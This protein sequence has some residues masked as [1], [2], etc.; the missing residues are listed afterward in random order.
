MA[1]Q[2]RGSCVAQGRGAKCGVLQMGTVKVCTFEVGFVED[3]R[4]E[5]CAPEF[6]VAQ[7]RANQA[8]TFK[9]RADQP[10]LA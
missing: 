2:G 1:T 7:V 6:C 10:R 3:G 5:M 4:L 8:G 9:V